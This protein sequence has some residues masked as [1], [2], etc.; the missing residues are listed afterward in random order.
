MKT[1]IIYA[2]KHGTTKK[3][4]NMIAKKLKTSDDVELINVKDIKKYNLRVF[5]KVIIGGSIHAGDIQKNIKKF[6]EDNKD[7]LKEKQ[8]GLFITCMFND[9]NIKEE[10]LHKAYS[11]ELRDA[12]KAQSVF[13]GEFLFE[14]MNFIEKMM[15]KIIAKT[16]KTT[17]KINKDEIEKFT[18][19]MMNK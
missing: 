15:V 3:I 4:A 6:C 2:T 18:K 12:S 17:S 10:Q 14:K 13:G 7:E 5:D 9:E 1:L 8:L 16:N 11:K 19:K